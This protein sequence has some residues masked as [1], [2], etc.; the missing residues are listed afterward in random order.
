MLGTVAGA[1]LAQR[2]PEGSQLLIF[3]P[4]MLV[5]A[6][7]MASGGAAS[8]QG[9]RKSAWAI[10]LA[11]IGVGLLTGLVGIG[12]GFLIVPALVLLLGLPMPRAVATSLL[13][14]VLNSAVGFGKYLMADSGQLQLDPTVIGLFIA[15]GGAASML[16]GRLGTRVPQALLRRIFAVV[17]VLVAVSILLS[18]F[19]S[20]A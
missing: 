1:W 20:F 19:V 12:G 13:L 18:K 6:W 2:L 4:V 17:L 14:I 11:G 3:A 7:R 16:G 15:I 9:P 10:A 5:A 8:V